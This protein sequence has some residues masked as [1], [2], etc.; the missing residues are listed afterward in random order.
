MPTS[1]TTSLY[2]FT[3]LFHVLSSYFSQITDLELPISM[4]IL[5]IILI[6]LLIL[7]IY[8]LSNILLNNKVISIIAIFAIF[9]F[10][11]EIFY[12]YLPRNIVLTLFLVLIFLLV[13]IFRNN[14]H[15]LKDYIIF[16]LLTLSLIL[17]HHINAI[18]AAT[19]ICAIAIPFF[20]IHKKRSKS[21]FIII[22]ITIAILLFILLNL[23]SFINQAFPIDTSDPSFK[24]FT[25]SQNNIPLNFL[26]PLLSITHSFFLIFVIAGLLIFLFNLR[27]ACGTQIKFLVI[28]PW[29][30]CSLLL[31]YQTSINYNFFASRAISLL[32]PALGIIGAYGFY[33]IIRLISRNNYLSNIIVLIILVLSSLYPVI[34]LLLANNITPI[35]YGLSREN[36]NE[37][38]KIK[39][40]FSNK[41]V[42]SDPSTMYLLTTIA[43]M[44]PAYNYEHTNLTR[45][46][47]IEW[48][49]VQQLFFGTNDE[50]TAYLSTTKYDYIIIS[51][52]TRE[53]FDEADFSRFENQNIIE[54]IYESDLLDPKDYRENPS[55][56][57]PYYSVYQSVQ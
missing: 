49:P 38:L 51:A 8:I 32:I 26:A 17:F 15:A 1:E 54:K 24:V 52:R 4:S 27:K 48:E 44:K 28:F 2:S 43:D 35:K 9:L 20:I 40:K 7:S 31:A 14:S 37:Q 22:C 56:K 23:P 34:T 16:S 45:N 21:L 42:L 57:Y 53:Y 36:V 13:K 5:N 46:K 11:Q 6:I 3:P 39:D 29:L 47:F 50:F 12:Y 18:Y 33:K 25:D 30:I 10:N 55:I 41:I 19:I